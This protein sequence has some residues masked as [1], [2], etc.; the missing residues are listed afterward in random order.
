MKI[1]IAGLGSIGQRHACNLR[2]LLGD[3]LELTAY[4]V[5]RTSPVINPDLTVDKS[6]DVEE[7]YGVRAFDDLDPALAD[8]PDAVFVTN[9]NVCHIPVALAAARA[10]CHVFVEKPLSHDLEGI[11]ELAELVE[12][13][14]LVCLVGYQLRFHPAFH[15]LRGLLADGALGSLISVRLDVGEHLPDMHRYEDYRGL[16]YGRRDQGGGV[17]LMQA[18]DLDIAYALF[19]LPRRVFALGGKRSSLE[20]DVEDTVAMLLDCAPVPVQVSQDFVRRPPVRRYEL[21]GEQATAVWDHVR[22]TLE[23]DGETLVEHADRNALFVEEAR[24]FLACVAGHETPA[25]GVRDAAASLRIALA[26]KRSIESGS[27]VTP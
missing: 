7:A 4:R 5:R 15:R 8:G 1:L 27:P 14:R 9:P 25:V 22:G 21:V 20:I 17:I 11:D 3:D 24:H 23:L 18:H 6:R 2:L 12:A 10:G 13:K 16:N 26:A 19:G